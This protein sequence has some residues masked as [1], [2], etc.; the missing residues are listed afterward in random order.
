MEFVVDGDAFYLLE[1][2]GR[3]QV[4]HPVTEEVLGIDLV[5]LQLDIASGLD[6][7]RG[8]APTA[9]GCAVEVR[10]IYQVIRSS[11]P[12]VV[13]AQM[14]TAFALIDRPDSRVVGLNLV[15]PEDG[16]VAM[17]DFDLHMRMLQYLRAERIVPPYQTRGYKLV[18]LV[19]IYE[20]GTLRSS[21]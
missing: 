19:R 1:L 13:F 8:L 16:R 3:I 5:A 4:E 21:A 17:A 12:S 18:E 15:A 20:A 11:P 14:M 10:Y 2:N 6:V 9:R 7:A